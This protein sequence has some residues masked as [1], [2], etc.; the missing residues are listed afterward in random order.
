MTLFGIY[1]LTITVK[2]SCL[3]KFRRRRMMSYCLGLRFVDV[4]MKNAC[5]G[6]TDR[7]I[8]VTYCATDIY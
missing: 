7:L 6:K 2:T 3:F 4:G 8:G 1:L 5:G